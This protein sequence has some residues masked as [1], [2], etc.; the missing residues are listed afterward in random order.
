M[1]KEQEKA[2]KAR[3]AGRRVFA[4]SWPAK[5]AERNVFVTSTLSYIEVLAGERGG[6]ELV[7]D[8]RIASRLSEQA[9]ARLAAAELP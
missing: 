7:Q 3:E 4:A 8:E 2:A 9:K 5:I 1:E 6:A